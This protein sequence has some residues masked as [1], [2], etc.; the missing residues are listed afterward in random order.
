MTFIGR[1]TI[2]VTFLL[3]IFLLALF[4]LPQ[5]LRTFLDFRLQL[6][7]CDGEPIRFVSFLPDG[8]TLASKGID[9]VAAH[10]WDVETGRQSRALRSEFHLSAFDAWALSPDGTILAAGE[11]PAIQIFEV[12]T[13]KRLG[14]AADPPKGVDSIAFLPDSKTLVA[15]GRGARFSCLML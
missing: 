3:V 2:I 4:A 9:D 14:G 1:K 11:F 15:W 13:S 7:G 5:G 12:G 8:K 10:F 6:P